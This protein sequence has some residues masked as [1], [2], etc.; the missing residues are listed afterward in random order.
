MN[1]SSVSITGYRS[2]KGPL[3]INFGQITALIG[4]NNVGKSNILSAMYRVLGR[5]WVTVNTFD[6]D[7][8]H[9]KNQEQDIC[10]DIVFSEPF[11]YE[12]FKGVNIAIPKLR[13]LYTRYKTGEFKSRRRLEKQCLKVNDELV[14]RYK[15]RPQKGKQP[16]FEPLATI[17]QEIQ[18]RI[19]VIYIGADRSLKSQLPG[20][21]GSMLA[22]LMDDIDKDFQRSD[23]MI[24]GKDSHG[25]EA[26][27]SRK[28]RFLM[29]M[30]AAMAALRTD[31]L[32]AL[33]TSI[34]NNAL[35]QLGFNPE[36]EGKNL[37]IQFT[38]LT[39]FDFYRS[40]ELFVSENG[41]QINATELGGGFQNA[42]VIAIIKSFEERKKQGAVFLIEEPEM[43]LHP[44]M[45]RSLY[46][47]L[48]NIGQNNQVIYVT[49]SPHFVTIPEF[50]EIRIISKTGVGT[51]FI[52][53]SLRADKKLKEK[54]RKE[55]D[56]ERNE[57]F[58]AK[59]LLIVEGDTEKLALPEYARR[60]DIDIDKN[61][62]TIIE[63]GGK[64]NIMNFL[65]LAL[66]LKIPAGLIYDEDS[67]DFGKADKEKEKAYNE[68]LDK[69]AE[70]GV[71]VWK[72]S[73]NYEKELIK[74]WGEQSYGKY[75]N[76]YGSYS[77]A[78]RARLF[79]QDETMPIPEFIKPVITWLAS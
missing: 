17:P 47:T 74:A 40:L 62:G 65:N 63:V 10:I 78:I 77:K 66:S 32:I 38:P 43:F 46:K 21:R 56:P 50:D 33:E 3:S 12:Q 52:Q 42:L 18:E 31:E 19:P 25:N 44:Q 68:T 5:D 20:A 37:D 13:F 58:F 60:L 70:N 55:L 9:M 35:H 22:S 29:C 73:S 39:S 16:E 75:C 24:K 28:D 14:L 76:Q 6:D 23:N 61:G 2:I 67:S 7:D 36:T 15:S 48:R 59:K 69:Y 79:A 4:A 72:L 1:I 57:L 27:M 30:K 51:Q 8:V 26:E 53:S 64:R 34:K 49:H 54:F 41:F 11:V 45:Q 71:S